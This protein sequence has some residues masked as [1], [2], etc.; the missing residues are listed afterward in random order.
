[1][2]WTDN[3]LS[4]TRFRLFAPGDTYLIYP[5]P[6]SSVRYERFIEGVALAEKVRLLREE[7]QRTNNT[8]ALNQLNEM[9]S[10]FQPAGIP[11]GRTA[12]EMVNALQQLVN[13]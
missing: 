13:K 6:R 1:M 2:N 11:Q 4:D 3:P 8:A 10:A 9:V 5:G 7:Y 12:A